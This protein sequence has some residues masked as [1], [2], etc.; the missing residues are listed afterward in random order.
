MARPYSQLGCTL[1]MVGI[2]AAC[3]SGAFCYPRTQSELNDALL[4]P[5][6]AVVSVLEFDAERLDASSER[7]DLD[8]QLNLDPSYCVTNCEGRPRPLLRHAVID[9]VLVSMSTDFDSATVTRYRGGTIMAREIDITLGESEFRDTVSFSVF[10]D[11]R[12]RLRSTGTMDSWRL[13]IARAMPSWEGVTV[14]IDPSA[15]PVNLLSFS[16]AETVT[17]SQAQ[18]FGSRAQEI[19]VGDMSA[20]VLETYARWLESEGF[21]GTLAR[22]TGGDPTLPRSP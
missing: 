7:D 22:E 11:G 6:C 12:V 15:Q 2:A 10:Q 5:R 17:L 20:D 8:F 21:T 14:E 19:R 9:N 18:A 13:L 16:D 1:V 4:N 3:D